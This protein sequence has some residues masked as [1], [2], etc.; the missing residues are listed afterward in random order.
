MIALTALLDAVLV[1][2]AICMARS[3]AWRKREIEFL[4]LG[5]AA[6]H[7]GNTALGNEYSTLVLTAKERADKWLRRD[8]IAF[9]RRYRRAA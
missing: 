2:G 3:L 9:L 4:R 8:P 1:V 5:I 6:F 7:D